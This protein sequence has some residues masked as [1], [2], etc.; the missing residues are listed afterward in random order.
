MTDTGF[1]VP[2]A[3]IDRLATAYW[4][5]PE[6]GTLEVF[7]PAAGGQWSKPPTFPSGGA[8]LVSTVDDFHTFSVMLASN[9]LLPRRAA[10]A[11]ARRS[12]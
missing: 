7:D 3:D 9:G 4:R 12:S 2:E 5:N 6:T 10:A 1:H 11:R 8:G